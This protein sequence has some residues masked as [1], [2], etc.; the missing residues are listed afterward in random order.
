MQL[1]RV[2]CKCSIF[3]TEYF[4]RTEKRDTKVHVGEKQKPVLKTKHYQNFSYKH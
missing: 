2:S 4:Q 1:L 3:F